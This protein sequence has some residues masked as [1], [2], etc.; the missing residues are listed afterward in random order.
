MPITGLVFSSRSLNISG[1]L[2]QMVL[3]V[4]QP[5]KCCELQNK[6]DLVYFWQLQGKS[7]R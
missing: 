3:K 4:P 2:E 7:L 6:I 1:H 5:L